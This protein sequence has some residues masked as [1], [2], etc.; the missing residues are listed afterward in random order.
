M[1]TVSLGPTALPAPRTPLVGREQEL[2]AARSLV[3]RDDVRL[4]TF[5]GAAGT[6]K[7]RLAL[8]VAADTRQSFSGGVFFVAL[9]STKDPA[10]VAPAV[11]QAIGAREIGS[12]EPAEALKEALRAVHAP[13]L[14]LLDKI[15]RAHV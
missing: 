11:V 9:A 2:A 4:V 6:G 8:Q 7:T 3:L 14:L 10:L 1:A 13:V 5:T 15:G 12:R